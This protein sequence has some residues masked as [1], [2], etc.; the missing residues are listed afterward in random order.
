MGNRGRPLTNRS[1]YW[2]E[3]H[4]K[5][6]YFLAKQIRWQFHKEIQLDEDELVNVGWFRQARYLPEVR[7][8][9][10]RIKLEMFKWAMNERFIVSRFKPL[11]ADEDNV[12]HR[13]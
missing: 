7:G 6:L 8:K 10:G 11:Q 2:S 1:N 4:L 3:G 5:L 13:H 9:S 12:V